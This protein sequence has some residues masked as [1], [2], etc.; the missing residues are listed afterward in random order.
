ME[1]GEA[2]PLCATG[3][4]SLMGRFNEALCLRPR[5]KEEVSNPCSSLCQSA[6]FRKFE[7]ERGVCKTGRVGGGIFATWAPPSSPFLLHP[8]PSSISGASALC[9]GEP[10]SLDLRRQESHM[11]STES[12]HEIM[13]TLFSLKTSLVLM[14]SSSP[15]QMESS[16]FSKPMLN[17]NRKKV[18]SYPNILKRRCHIGTPP[19]LISLNHFAPPIS[20]DATLKEQETG[21]TR[22]LATNQVL[23]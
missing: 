12:S 15:T 10:G 21:T 7:E 14:E 8:A 19:N 18:V 22:N 20:A 9:K 23:C 13:A 2:C 11:T 17:T 16:H 4:C 3:N 5:G 6:K 1:G